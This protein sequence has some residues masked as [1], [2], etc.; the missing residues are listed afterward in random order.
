MSELL[1]VLRINPD[2]PKRTVLKYLQFEPGPHELADVE[3]KTLIACTA[4]SGSSLLQV[5]LERYGLKCQEFF[6]VEG[7]ARQLAQSGE[8]RTTRDFANHLAR[9]ATTDGRFVV[10]GAF[11]SFLF[12]CYLNEVANL[13]RSWKVVF[14]RRRNVVRQAISMSIAAATQ[15]WTFDMPAKGEVAVEDYSFDAIARQLEVVHSENQI[16][17][18][19]FGLFNLAPHRIFYETYTANLNEQT[20]R[21]AQFAGVDTAKFPDARNHVPRLKSQSTGIND[22]WERRFRRDVAKKLASVTDQS[23]A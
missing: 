4:R 5:A 22:E 3:H 9:H 7:L 13:R 23:I 15:Q 21:I 14:L 12:L 17:E 8:A 20:E 16:W 18:R 1:K 2:L 19:I 10:K 6:N 11:V